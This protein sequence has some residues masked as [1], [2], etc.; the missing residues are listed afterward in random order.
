[1][2]A[3]V[4][5][6]AVGGSLAIVFA[7]GSAILSAQA[8]PP[9]DVPGAVK[10]YTAPRT[11]WGD[12][13]LQGIWPG[14]ELVGV[15]MQRPANFGTRNWL[16]DEEFAQRQSQAERQAE[17]DLAE[18]DIGDT[19]AGGAVGGPVSP[20]PHWLERGTPQRIASLVV[21]PPDGRTPPTTEAYREL[22]QARNQEA[23]VR[24]ASL[25]GREADSYT[26]RSIY[27]R[28]IT[29]GIAGSFL[30]VIY[31]NGNEIVQGPGWV[32]LR[33]EMIHETRIAPLDGRAKLNGVIT[34]WMGDSRARWEGDTLVVET[35]NFN[36]RTS[37]IGVN[38]GGTRGS[39]AMKVIERITRVAPDLLVWD[40]TFD[41]PNVWTRP[42]TIR[43][44]LKLDNDY[45]MAEYACHEGNYTMFNILSGARADEKLQEEAKAKGLPN[46]L[47]PAGGRGGGGRGGAGGRGG[48]G[49]RGGRGQ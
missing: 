14:I 49:G 17:Q 9:T 19:P 32:A 48:G 12:P 24:R 8:P 18:F 6:T 4:L 44:P 13:D 15:P 38:G 28:C 27:D 41:D 26:D 1:M 3:R 20:P 47:Q 21:D 36:E 16:T 23:Q 34:S 45:L 25:E 22:Q 39:D 35:T 11:S 46:P 33:N 10:G 30:P 42:W 29:R 7:A 2:N 40:M 43:L 37:G 31:N 5:R